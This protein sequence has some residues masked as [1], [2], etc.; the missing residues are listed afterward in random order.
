M[1]SEVK[2]LFNSDLDRKIMTYLTLYLLFQLGYSLFFYFVI[3]NPLA[4]FARQQA[5][6]TFQP[7]TAYLPVLVIS[8]FFVVIRVAIDCYIGWRWMKMGFM[9][10]KFLHWGLSYLAFLG[11]VG[12]NIIWGILQ[13]LYLYNFLYL[14]ENFFVISGLDI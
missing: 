5:A 10:P 12:I 9:L 1:Y 7:H 6:I 14:P 2:E 4:S 11:V 3:F 13:Y 8:I